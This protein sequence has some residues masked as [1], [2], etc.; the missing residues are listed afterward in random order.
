MA[1]AALK[2]PIDPDAFLD[3]EQR[4]AERY[5]LVAGEVR[6]MV[7]GTIG[8]N[9]VTDNIH[10][11]LRSRLRGTPCRARAVQTRVQAGNDSFVYPDI[12]VSCSP[13]RP[14][15][16]FI[17]DPVLVVEVLSPSTA[18]YDQGEKRWVYQAIPSLQQLVLVSPREAKV[19]L[20]TRQSDDSWRSVFV[21]GLE[22]VLP[23]ESLDLSLSL[24][25]V[26]ADTA[27]AGKPGPNRTAP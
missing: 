8:H 7:G 12:V 19:E 3:W 20:V 11:A 6:L 18:Q 15:E 10:A 4:Q 27:V 21:T 5:E 1:L 9:D 13:R 2:Q 23:L 26:Y 22:A 17:D 25:D 14:E 16:L 24:A